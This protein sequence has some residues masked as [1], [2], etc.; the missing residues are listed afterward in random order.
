[1]LGWSSSWTASRDSR[2][3]RSRFLGSAAGVEDLDRDAAADS[4]TEIL[5][6][7][8]AAEPTLTEEAVDPVAG[9]LAPDLELVAH[10]TPVPPWTA[11]GVY[12]IALPR[13]PATQAAQVSSSRPGTC[14]GLGVALLT[15]DEHP[16]PR[17][18]RSG[19]A[20]A[21]ELGEGFDHA[22]T[23]VRLRRQLVIALHLVAEALL[24]VRPPVDDR[25]A[26]ALDHRMMTS[27]PA[28]VLFVSTAHGHGEHLV[29]VLGE[30]G[31]GAAEELG[32]VG[33]DA[34]LSRLTLVLVVPPGTAAA[35]DADPVGHAVRAHR[36]CPS[37]P[38]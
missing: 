12:A 36:G 2:W 20:T 33:L 4:R 15:F 1:M 14:S 29:P 13:S 8:D 9:E 38:P 30:N 26:G 17:S 28:R 24:V 27:S 23:R 35:A 31:F 22:V 18:S 7:V 11:G 19:R 37:T 5:G 10:A 34:L 25:T 6:Q 3:K 32:E 21:V 16:D